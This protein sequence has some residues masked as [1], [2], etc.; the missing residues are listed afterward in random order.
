MLLFRKKLIDFNFVELAELNGN[1]RA[2][3]TL[4]PSCII[5][6][7]TAIGTSRDS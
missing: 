3:L 2:L 1:E 4:C 5:G 6:A 7:I